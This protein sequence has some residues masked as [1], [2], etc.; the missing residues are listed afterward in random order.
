MKQKPVL[1]NS[2]FLMLFINTR[3]NGTG[4]LFG[5]VIAILLLCYLIYTIVKPEK[6]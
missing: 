3:V 4:Y 6:F 5:G 2:P 1:M